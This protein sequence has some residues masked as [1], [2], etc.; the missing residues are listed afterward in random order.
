MAYR[1]LVLAL[2][3]VAAA[4]SSL[5]THRSAAAITL[6]S[7]HEAA[8]FTHCSGPVRVSCVVDG[9][10][11]WYRGA[12]IRIADI[13]APETSEPHCAAEARLGAR[14]TRRLAE[15]LSAGAFSLEPA[16]RLRD[17][18][19]RRLFTVTRGGESLGGK[20]EAEGLAEPWRGY[21]RDWC[22]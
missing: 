11:F 19:G 3:A 17:S 4:L 14:A 6:P 8:R 10:T 18:Y 7:D 1:I 21:R 15:L 9:D 12:K 22:S 16:D 5:A 13:N 20:L 2:F